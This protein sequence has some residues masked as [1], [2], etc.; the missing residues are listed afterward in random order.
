MTATT[1]N[2][3]DNSVCPYFMSF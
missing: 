3:H 1:T 2:R